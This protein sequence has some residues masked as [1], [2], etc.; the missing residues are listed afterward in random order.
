MD[1]RQRLYAIIRERSFRQGEVFRLVS[2]RTSTIYFN[3]KPTM[4]DP[5]GARLIGAALA[6][7]AAGLGAD[8]VGGLAMG[9]VPLVAAAAAMSAVAGR[10]VRALFVRKEAKDHGTGSQIEGLAEGEDL[11]GRKVVVVEDVTT[12]GGS[13]MK[14]IAALRAAGAGVDHVVTIVDRQE[15]AEEAFAAEGVTLHA[16][17]RKSDFGSEE[18]VASGE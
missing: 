18:T 13:A 4:L 9:A 8:H 10:P 1:D 7:R 11:A 3:L 16:L 12:T 2:G 14:A 5:D 15:G 6:E 17:Y